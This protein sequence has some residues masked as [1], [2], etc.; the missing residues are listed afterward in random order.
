MMKLADEFRRLRGAIVA[1]RAE[2][3]EL[4]AAIKATTDRRSRTVRS[5][6]HGMT[7]SRA[8]ETQAHGA[9]AKSM[10]RVRR[11]EMRESLS[12][13][14][15]ART[16]MGREHRHE[17]D[18]ANGE[19]NV[20][21]TGLMS[22]FARERVAQRLHRGEAAAAQR[23]QA[24][25]FMSDLTSR[26]AGLRDRLAKEGRDRAEAIR[27]T[28]AARSSDRIAA[29]AIWRGSSAS[30]APVARS[31]SWS[32]HP[33]S[34]ADAAASSGAHRFDNIKHRGSQEYDGDAR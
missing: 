15:A 1:S 7:T 17:A 30:Q 29:G 21:I 18:A 32:A 13:T 33:A 34:P 2:R 24:S 12:E 3:S 28:F 31:T 25:A 5:L 14:K 9:Q 16:E 20:E 6:L 8:S 26:V 10:V 23:K 4:T 19:R 27:S 11:S 22:R